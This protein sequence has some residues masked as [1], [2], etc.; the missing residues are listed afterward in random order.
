VQTGA[1]EKIDAALL[2]R[3]GE[4]GVDVARRVLAALIGLGREAEEA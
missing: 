2:G 3:V 1:R 4:K